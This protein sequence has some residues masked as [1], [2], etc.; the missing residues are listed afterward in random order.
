MDDKPIGVLDSGVG[1]LT[2]W[3]E[4]ISLLSYESTIYIGDSLHAPY[5]DKT[6]E[7]IHELSRKLIQFLLRKKV[8]LIVI[9]CNTITT[10]CLDALRNEFRQ[11]PIIGT[12]PVVKKAVEETKTKRIGILSTNRTA[13]SYYQKHLLEQHADGVG[14][15]NKGTN[16]LVPLIEKGEITGIKIEKILH[17]V[18]KP[19]QEK[20]VDILA[21]GCT[22]FPFLRPEME[23]ILGQRVALLDS[24]SA[25]AR[26][27]RRVL[28]NN[29]ILTKKKKATHQLYTTGEKGVF[30]KIVKTLVTE[31]YDIRR[32]TI[33]I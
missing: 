19:F 21:L 28:T 22:H 29:N 32:A 30:S 33:Q 8:K 14:V 26:Q 12:V 10:V 25:I 24:G 3:K 7:E 16:E 13:N 27:V 20:R 2:V 1:G 31:G 9:A 18:L 4:I 23:K 15:V 17:K 6:P 5:G 11:I